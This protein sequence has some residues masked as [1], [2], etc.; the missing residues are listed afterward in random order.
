MNNSKTKIERRVMVMTS[1]NEHI[2]NAVDEKNKVWKRWK[3]E[4]HR[5]E[6]REERKKLLEL[7]IV[8]KQWLAIRQLAVC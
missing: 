3:A 8:N 5:E 1:N 6:R 4:E 2:D 7:T